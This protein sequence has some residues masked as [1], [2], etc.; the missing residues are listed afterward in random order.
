M[1]SLSYLNY[2][3]LLRI[4]QMKFFA[5]GDEKR[6]LPA[7]FSAAAFSAAAFSAAAFS[8]PAKVGSPFEPLR[9]N[10]KIYQ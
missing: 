4:R 10:I 3:T 1:A 9:R 8:A 2:T 5:S 6:F 7:A